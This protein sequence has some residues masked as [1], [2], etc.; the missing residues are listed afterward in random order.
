MSQQIILLWGNISIG[1]QSIESVTQLRWLQFGPIYR[2]L[3]QPGAVNETACFLKKALSHEETAGGVT[4]RWWFKAGPISRM[5]ANSWPQSE[6]SDRHLKYQT[7]I[8][9][10]VGRRMGRFTFSRPTSPPVGKRPAVDPESYLQPMRLDYWISINPSSWQRPDSGSVISRSPA[11]AV[12]GTRMRKRH[13][14]KIW[15]FFLRFLNLYFLIGL[16]CRMIT[17]D[18]LEENV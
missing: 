4:R 10:Q 9:P 13:I 11:A 14:V 5:V 7:D 6:I 17:N 3:T 2:T 16:K 15:L 12:R 18:Y 1:K 8:Y